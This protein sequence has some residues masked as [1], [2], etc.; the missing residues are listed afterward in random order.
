MS[1]R[2]IFYHSPFSLRFRH[3]WSSFVGSRLSGR[4]PFAVDRPTGD[5]TERCA[6]IVPGGGTTAE[7]AGAAAAG[8]RA[9]AVFAGPETF[10]ED[11]GQP[12]TTAGRPGRCGVAR[13]TAGCEGRARVAAADAADIADPAQSVAE[14]GGERGVRPDARPHGVSGDEP[15]RELQ[16]GGGEAERQLQAGERQQPAAGQVARRD[17]ADGAAKGLQPSSPQ[18]H[19]R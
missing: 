1:K 16:A 11:V 3:N 18:Q 9:A 5:Q 6:T 10:G 17:H 4:A 8:A 19:P 15:G 7:R 14:G 2:A 12:A 13:P